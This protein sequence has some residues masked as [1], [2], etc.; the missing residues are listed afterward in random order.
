MWHAWIAIKYWVGGILFDTGV[1]VGVAWKRDDDGRE[2][3][4]WTGR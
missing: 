2:H 3:C 1:L 4:W